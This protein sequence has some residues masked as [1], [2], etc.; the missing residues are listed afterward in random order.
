MI[1]NK[2][3]IIER[4]NEI[5]T[6]MHELENEAPILANA[7]DRAIAR[8]NKAQAMFCQITMAARLNESNDLLEEVNDIQRSLGIL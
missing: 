2:L 8:G 4:L 7:L 5:E 3:E 1:P 6:R